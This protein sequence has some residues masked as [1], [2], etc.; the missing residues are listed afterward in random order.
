VCSAESL[1]DREQPD[2]AGDDSRLL[3]TLKALKKPVRLQ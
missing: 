3:R 2:D 1:F